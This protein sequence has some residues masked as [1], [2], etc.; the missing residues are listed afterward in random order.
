MR[1]RKFIFYSIRQLENQ[2]EIISL[3]IP[4]LPSNMP[5]SLSHP[6]Q[7]I[8]DCVNA[9][10]HD[11]VIFTGSGCTSA[12]HKLIQVLDLRQEDSPPIVFA[13]PFDHHSTILPWREFTPDVSFLLIRS[14]RKCLLSAKTG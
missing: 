4:T 3:W 1:T 5:S 9:S 8:R 13:G 14:T 10:E 2:N 6:R 12:V 11:A 7:I